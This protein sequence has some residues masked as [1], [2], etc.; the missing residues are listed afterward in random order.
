MKKFIRK[1]DYNNKVTSDFVKIS[2]HKGW[3]EYDGHSSE[4]F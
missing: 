2:E 4:G 3:P 1:K